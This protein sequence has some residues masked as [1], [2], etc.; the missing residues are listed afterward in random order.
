MNGILYMGG[1]EMAMVSIS[2]Y[3]FGLLVV[4]EKKKK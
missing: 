3:T 4:D 1:Q 2:P